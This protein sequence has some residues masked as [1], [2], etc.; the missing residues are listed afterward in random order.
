LQAFPNDSAAHLLHASVLL[1]RGERLE[2]RKLLQT[3][4]DSD[5]S[6]AQAYR[7][8]ALSILN[9]SGSTSDLERAGELLKKAVTLDSRDADVYRLAGMVYAQL[10]RHRLAA[11]AYS[12]LCTLEPASADA[13]IGLA[14]SYSMLGRPDL[15][16]R[17]QAI[18]RELR[19]RQRQ[20]LRL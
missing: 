18:Y 9:G 15:S 11:Q 1:Q 13:R 19:E 12:T 10:G 14:Q 2:S 4:L 20:L 16:D 6:N 3:I 8:M 17:Q 7:L 5:P